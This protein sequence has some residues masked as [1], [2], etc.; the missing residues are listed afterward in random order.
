MRSWKNW[1]FT[2][3]KTLLL[4]AL[5]VTSLPVFFL[6]H[7]PMQVFMLLAAA[8]L[9]VDKKKLQMPVLGIG[10]LCV[11]LLAGFIGVENITTLKAFVQIIL[12]LL[13]VAAAAQLLSGKINFYLL[14]TPFLLIALWLFFHTSIV[15]L[16]YTV[17]ELFLLAALILL[18][19][20]R[21]TPAAAVKVTLKIFMLSVPLI[22]VLFLFFPRISFERGDFGFSDSQSAV[23]GHDGTMYTGS[24]ALNVLSQRKVME[25]EITQ[26]S[27]KTPLY[28]R[29]SVMYEKNATSWREEEVAFT[30]KPLEKTQ[31]LLAYDIILQPHFQEYIY[32]VDYPLDAIEKA[33]RSSA[34]TIY[35]QE[36]VVEQ[37]R[38]SLRSAQEFQAF[39]NVPQ[40]AKAFDK[41]ANQKLQEAAKKY[42]DQSPQE[43][44]EALK[45]LFGRAGL[46][47][48]LNPP[49]FDNN[50]FADSFLFERK[51]GYCVHFASAFATAARIFDLPSRVVTGYLAKEE[52]KI[53]DY[54]VIRQKDAHA[55]SE[56][57]LP[58]RGWVRVDA[59]TMAASS[60]EQSAQAL[61][62]NSRSYLW[63]NYIKYKLQKWV[64]YYNYLTQNSFFEALRSDQGFLMRF[65]GSIL[66]LGVVGVLFFILIKGRGCK[67]KLQCLMQ[68]LLKKA[69]KKG[70]HWD[71]RQSL[72]TFLQQSGDKNLREIADEYVKL[73][74]SKEVDKD[75]LRRLKRRVNAY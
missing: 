61:S 18:Y 54:Y 36:K 17:F 20:M 8:A 52:A 6:L 50:D 4:I 69:A 71:K 67:D 26:G 14:I 38:Y 21:T 51:K 33:K 25:L 15:A 72:H 7:L 45:T 53:E 30:P 13:L 29:G 43:R 10:L 49:D 48:T 62:Q 12:S 37:K 3:Q 1:H 47:Y 55:W 27:V 57:Y 41:E 73:R 35:A 63:L 56:V 66:G 32:S 19:Q 68:K 60:D 74:Y 2:D 75:A 39:G 34:Y 44:F 58:K 11:G 42:L 31:D 40:K 28:L 23:A 16:F 70:Q 65:V 5:G 64:L 9:I 24:R 46:Q 22:V 59:T